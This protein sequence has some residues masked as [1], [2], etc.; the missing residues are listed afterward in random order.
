[1]YLVIKEISAK[2]VLP[3]DGLLH[4]SICYKSLAS[5]LLLIWSKEMK[6]AKV[7]DQDCWEGGPSYSA[8]ST[9][10]SYR[11]GWQDPVISMSLDITDRDSQQMLM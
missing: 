5:Q 11:S 4:V 10:T 2:G 3:H 7:Q 1:L 8:C 6:I 9:I